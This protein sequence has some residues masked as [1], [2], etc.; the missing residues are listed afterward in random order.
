V[1][2]AIRLTATG[3]LL[4]AGLVMS[5]AFAGDA[6]QV[7][8]GAIAHESSSLA[9]NEQAHAA[10]SA[11][12]LGLASDEKL[13]VKA[14]IEDADGV[15][16]VRYERTLHGLRVIGGDLVVHKDAKGAVEQV[17]YNHGRKS[18]APASLTPKVS[19]A[20]ARAKGLATAQATKDE[21]SAGNEL[22][23]LV[24]DQGPKLAYDVLTTGIR[25]NQV[26]NR[27]RR[28]HLRRQRHHQHDRQVGRRFRDERRGGQHGHR[29]AQP[30]RPQ[31][32]CGP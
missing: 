4:A 10:A 31:H 13:T 7:P 23:V 27:H 25:A 11:S 22:V 1:N 12:A 20:S 28:R 14:V 29:R 24:T 8:P 21:K 6:K 32:G 15:S 2:R 26:P 16:H 19:K 5:P 18:I 17:T 9:A 3:G 30:G